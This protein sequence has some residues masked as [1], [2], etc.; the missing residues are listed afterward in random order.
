M[1][2]LE[3]EPAAPRVRELLEDARDGSSDVLFSA[4][5]AGEVAYQIE[6]RHGA[7]VAEASLGAIDLLPIR[8]IDVTW[9]RILAAAHLK[10]HHRLSY[11]DAFA[12]ALAQEMDATLVTGDPEFGCLESIIHIEWL[13]RR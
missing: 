1:A 8:L 11:A 9:P 3:R 12:A 2:L 7:E 10:A 6:R 13:P 4:I 5:N